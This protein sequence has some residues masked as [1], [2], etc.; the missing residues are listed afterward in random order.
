ML[1]LRLRPT[2]LLQRKRFH[3]ILLLQLL[4]LFLIL[5]LDLPLVSKPHLGLEQQQL[6]LLQFLLEQ[7]LHR[8][9]GVQPPE[10]M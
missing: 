2:C 10:A 3:P 1:M 5:L 8:L 7:L 9:L 6:R 4:L